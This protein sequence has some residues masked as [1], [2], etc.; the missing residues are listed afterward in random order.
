MR[1]RMERDTEEELKME[2]LAWASFIPKP[3]DEWLVSYRK[4]VP[5][6]PQHVKGLRKRTEH[7][8]AWDS[9]LLD[10]WQFDIK[11]LF[12]TA[13]REQIIMVSVRYCKTTQS[14][15]HRILDCWSA[16]KL[17]CWCLFSSVTRIRLQRK[18][19]PSGLYQIEGSVSGLWAPRPS[20]TYY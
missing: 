20:P 15:N 12:H 16:L 11:H 2:V 5:V 13:V 3:A 8:Q 17:H 18:I 4:D 6:Q 19:K 1:A 9:L 7:L 10:F 14:R